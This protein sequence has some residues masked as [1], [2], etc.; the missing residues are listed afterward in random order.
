[1]TA[2]LAL[3]MLLPVCIS[4]YSAKSTWSVELTQEDKQ[5]NQKEDFDR[6]H[7][8]RI[9]LLLTTHNAPNRHDVYS[10]RIQWW[11]DNSNFAIY[12]VDSTNNSFSKITVPRNHTS[13]FKVFHFDQNQLTSKE[14][15]LHR[16]FTLKKSSS[17]YE[18]VSLQRAGQ[19]FGSEL[20]QYLYVIKLT[21]KYVVP[22]LSHHLFN[23]TRAKGRKPMLMVQGRRKDHDRMIPS[24]LFGFSGVIMRTIFEGLH[25]FLVRYKEYQLMEQSLYFVTK[26]LGYATYHLPRMRIPHQFRIAR[27]DGSMLAYLPEVKRVE[28]KDESRDTLELQGSH[29][30]RDSAVESRPR[31]S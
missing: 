26:N 19:K 23:I 16:K 9:A 24:E 11:L 22:S 31:D 8:P 7:E 12:V 17:F 1:M 14:E 30:S 5:Q 27:G 29:E 6:S 13:P 2:L 28:S 4:G 10:P 21:G 3:G 15:A 18:L 20:R 25:N